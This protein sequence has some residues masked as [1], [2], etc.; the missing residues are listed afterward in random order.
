MSGHRREFGPTTG[1][2]LL[3]ILGCSL[4]VG[5]CL[6]QTATPDGEGI[7]Y[8]RA[9]HAQLSAIRDYRACRDHGLE[10]DRAAAPRQQ[11]RSLAV[12]RI[13]EGCERDLGTHAGVVSAEERMQALAVAVLARLRGGDPEGAAAALARMRDGFPDRDLYFADGSSFRDSVEAVLQ[14]GRSGATSSTVAA[15]LSA[16]LAAELRRLEEWR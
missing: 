11:G 4:A 7:D 9:R 2:R 16:P 6:G 8:R 10:L 5:G 1:G 3:L 13:L 14:S 15:N 12:A